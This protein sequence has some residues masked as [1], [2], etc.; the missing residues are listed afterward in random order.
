VWHDIGT[1]RIG[2]IRNRSLESAKEAAGFIRGGTPVANAAEVTPAEVI[3]IA[4][5][6]DAIEEA[7]IR[8]AQSDVLRPGDLVFHASG[9][10]SSA[11][12]APVRAAG[13]HVG[14]VHPIHSFADPARSV[15]SFVGTHCALEGD[16]AALPLLQAAFSAIGGQVF[17]ID[18][19]Q[20]LLYH[21][22]TVFAANYL[23]AL[24][25][26]SRRCL[27]QAGVTGDALDLVRPMVL[28]TA[29]NV[30][31]GNPV[32]ALTGPIARGDTGVVERQLAALEAW[33]GEVA[34]LYRVMGRVAT[35]L[36][37]QKGTARP[38]A[39]ARLR[40]LLAE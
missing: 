16:E 35:E 8:L 28:K 11:I 36:S 27:A 10:L 25:E 12:L 33:D 14:N 40:E 4:T 38:E 29:D 32:Q 34:T 24:L 19:E 37:E 9:S 3:L 5:P 31:A 18:G 17:H 15:D 20:K 30:F 22:S 39:L 13:A 6:D 2:C 7:A 23:V 1:L 26:V 21:A